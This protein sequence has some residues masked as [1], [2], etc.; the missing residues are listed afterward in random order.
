MYFWI[1]KPFNHELNKKYYFHLDGDN[2]VKLETG[3]IRIT[4][5][6]S[7]KLPKDLQ[8]II[9]PELNELPDTANCYTIFVPEQVKFETKKLPE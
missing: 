5:D 6:A 7:V 4:S 2:D 8:E 9:A 3:E 1:D